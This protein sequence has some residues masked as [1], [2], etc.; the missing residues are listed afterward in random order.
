MSSLK[1]TGYDI[2][3][4]TSANSHDCVKVSRSLK[5]SAN[6]TI[7]MTTWRE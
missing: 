2:N 4:M 6:L 3:E 1:K 5:I 7:F